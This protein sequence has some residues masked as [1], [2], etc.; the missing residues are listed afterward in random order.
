MLSVRSRTLVS[1]HE[2]VGSDFSKKVKNFQNFVSYQSIP[3]C[4]W[5]EAGKAID[6]LRLA[7]VDIGGS[8]SFL[9]DVGGSLTKTIDRIKTK[10]IQEKM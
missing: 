3:D 8:R 7:E 4:M 2:L 10:K 5:A 6:V 1:L 9:V